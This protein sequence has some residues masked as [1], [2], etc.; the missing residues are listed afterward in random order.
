MIDKD[1]REVWYR[2]IE[3]GFYPGILFGVRTY[4]EQWRTNVVLYTPF[5]IDI[6]FKTVYKEVE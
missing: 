3:I 4:E 6:C 2:G 5:F 1:I